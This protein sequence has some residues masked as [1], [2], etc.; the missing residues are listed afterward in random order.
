MPFKHTL[1]HQS[2]HNHLLTP[3]RGKDVDMT[4]GDITRHIVLFALP[5]LAGN[6]FQQMYNMVD[7][8]V[9]GRFVSN[10]AYAAV[11]TAGPIINMLIGFFMGLSSGAGVV[12]SQFYGAKR[13]DQVHRTVHTA[14]TMTLVMGV[15]LTAIGMGATPFL[16]RF[17][18]TPPMV[19]PESIA[20]LRI[21][22]SGAMGMLIY[23]MGA[24]ILRAVGDSKRPFY[25]LVVCAIANTVLDLFF[26]IVLGMGVQGVALATIL[27]QG[28]S[29]ALILITLLRTRDCIRLEL[30]QLR[31]HWDMLGKIIRVGIPAAVQMAIT[32]FANIFAQSH[33]NF[34]GDNCMS[35]WTTYA[36]VDQLIFLPM[37]S[38]ALAATT[39]VGQNL[40][41]GQVERAR[42]GV[43]RAL[44]LSLV[45]TFVAMIP[46]ISFAPRIVYFFNRKPEVV[47]Y[48]TLL[49]RWITPF[50]LVCCFTQVY[51]G[52]LRGAGN[53][54]APMVMML[55]SFVAFRQAYLFVM[56][57]VWN[58]VLPI[59]MAYPAGWI[60]CTVLMTIYYHRYKSRLGEKLLVED[61]P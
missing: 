45:M 61:K 8:W 60:L 18:K 29:A 5:L 22:F 59:A 52:A 7:T 4:Q 31:L 27:S 1:K 43:N 46:V 58:E 21:Y 24:A 19:M 2:H 11:G 47:E 50:Y 56:S 33:I 53:S 42:K 40:G 14:V 17:M 54:Q 48:G 32:A 30:R 20:Y 57:R 34:F 13:Y 55:T 25:Y 23:N 10:E 39:F 36:K 15:V 49:L 51:A 16:L 26:V 6:L 28:I 38:I 12:I 9:V 35:G 44:G 37:Q 41:S 3:K